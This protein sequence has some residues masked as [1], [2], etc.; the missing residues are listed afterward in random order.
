MAYTTAEGRQEL[1]DG[2]A[3][4][5]DE[6]GHALAALGAAYE[7]LDVATADTLEEEL[8]GPTQRAYGRAKRTHAA[9]AERSGLAPGRFEPQEPGLPSTGA[10]G[11]IDD[12]T[13]AAGTAGAKLATLQDSPML[14]EV[15]DGEL[16]AGIAEIRAIVD[17]L[18]HAARELTR[19][20]G[21]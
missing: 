9:F 20:L 14:I 12:A 18:P 10:R 1:L 5:I 21:R 6:L 13:I 3:E 8:F 7:Q 4:A 15:G 16:R 17:G 19:R 2:L 11:F